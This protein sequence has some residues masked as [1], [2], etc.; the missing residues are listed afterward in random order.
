MDP[1][2]YGLPSRLGLRTEI[3]NNNI[4]AI[5][6][7]TVRPLYFGTVVTSLYAT[8]FL[9]NLS[10]NSEIQVVTLINSISSYPSKIYLWLDSSSFIEPFRG[11]KFTFS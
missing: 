9:S 8:A 1:L 5:S 2:R 4:D 6:S 11:I 7:S 10:K 3:Y